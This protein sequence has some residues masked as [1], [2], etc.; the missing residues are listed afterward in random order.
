MKDA[1]VICEYCD[2][3]E[4]ERRVRMRVHHVCIFVAFLA[5]T[6]WI[7]MQV[8]VRTFSSRLH[9]KH[10]GPATKFIDFIILSVSQCP[11]IQEP[12]NCIAGACTNLW[13]PSD[14]RIWMQFTP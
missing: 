5:K 14:Y 7:G 1:L 6:Y 13:N 8:Y 2:L 4:S 11:Q 9:K 12:N 3:D 10:C